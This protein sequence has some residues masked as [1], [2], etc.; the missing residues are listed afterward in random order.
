MVNVP[1]KENRHGREM[2]IATCLVAI[3]IKMLSMIFP[4]GYE[5]LIDCTLPCV[6]VHK[7][8]EV[9]S[10]IYRR[11]SRKS[12]LGLHLI[13]IGTELASSGVSDCVLWLRS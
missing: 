5:V 4:I 13:A 1:G 8:V 11:K 6:S 2:R 7:E 10:E 9:R 12:S 3:Q